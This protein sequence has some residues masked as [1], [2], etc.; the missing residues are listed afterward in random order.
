VL[1]RLN[2]EHADLRTVDQNGKELERPDLDVVLDAGRV[3]VEV[4]DAVQRPAARKAAAVSMVQ[5]EVLDALDA[6][7]NLKTALGKHYLI[8]SM[9]SPLTVPAN[10][11]LGT[12]HVRAIVDELKR[13]IQAGGHRAT[14]D[15]I[16][17][18]DARYP[19]LFKR[20]ATF[21]SSLL[22]G[23][24]S[25]SAGVH[26]IPQGPDT[27]ELI[28]TLNKHRK[29]AAGYRPGP[30][31]IVLYLADGDEIVRGTIEAIGQN[32][33]AFDPFARCFVNDSAGGCAEL[34]QAGI[35]RM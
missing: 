26:F 4:A 24:I 1:S 18:F 12:K 27:A 20:A 13:L 23:T 22:T 9:Q 14:L 29:K 28:E 35:K 19:A 17:P 31:W 2:I 25:V 6:D 3:G 11:D 8:V 15:R 10:A 33:P 5:R 34:T 21:H 32:P 16:M 7:K 30:N